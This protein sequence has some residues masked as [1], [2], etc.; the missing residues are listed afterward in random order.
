MDRPTERG[1]RRGP[2]GVCTAEG[3]ILTQDRLLSRIKETERTD[4]RETG[5]QRARELSLEAR[6]E[7]SMSTHRWGQDLAGGLRGAER[8]HTGVQTGAQSERGCW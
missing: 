6:V 5:R 1:Q 7:E 2:D 3:N 8:A 4:E